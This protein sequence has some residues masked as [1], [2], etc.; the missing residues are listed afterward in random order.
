MCHIL[1][2]HSYVDRHLGCFCLLAVL[3]SAAITWVCKH[4]FNTPLSIILGIH[5]E[6]GL[7]D[8]MAVLI[9]WG[10]SMLLSKAVAPFTIPKKAH[11]VVI[12]SRPHQ[13]L[14]FSVFLV[15]AILI[16]MRW[17]PNRILACMSLM[18]SDGQHLYICF[19][20]ICISSLMKCLFKSFAIFNVICCWVV[21]LF[22]NYYYI[23]WYWIFIICYVPSKMDTLSG[24]KTC[25]LYVRWNLYWLNYWIFFSICYIPGKRHRNK[26]SVHSYF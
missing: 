22:L 3:N 19:W 15:V 4:P 2:I 18:I 1:L 5:P 12:C 17:Y 24:D 7:L 11:G 20:A 23:Y 21:I 26:L 25:N 8:H 13:N 16:G 6:V 9:I 10:I 14:L